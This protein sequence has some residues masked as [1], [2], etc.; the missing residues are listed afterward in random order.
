MAPRKELRN[1]HQTY[2]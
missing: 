2:L 1:L